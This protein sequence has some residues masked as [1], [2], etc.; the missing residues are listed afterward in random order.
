MLYADRRGVGQFQKWLASIT[1]VN[2]GHIERCAQMSLRL[3]E[4]LDS[5]SNGNYENKNN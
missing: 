4:K 5:I 1:A 2:G 3:D